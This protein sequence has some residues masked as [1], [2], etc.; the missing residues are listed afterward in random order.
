[1]GVNS[2][3][4]SELIPSR[5][6][7]RDNCLIVTDHIFSLDLVNDI[8]VIGAGKASAAMGAEIEKIL[9]SRI[10]AGHIIVKKGHSCRLK[11]IKVTEAGHP[12]PDNN[13][14]E[15]TQSIL[16]MVSEANANDLV[17]CLISGG[18]SS[19]LADHPEGSSPGEMILLNDLLVRSGASISEIN[20]VRKHLSGVKGG[21][22]ARAIYPATCIS[23]ILSDVPGD[24]LDVI[25]SGP[26][27]PDTT[28]FDDAFGVLSK[29]D[30]VR[31]MPQSLL[32]HII[33]GQDGSIPETPHSADTI[34]KKTYNILIGTNS[35]ALE[36]A[37]QKALQHN[38]NAIIVETELQGDV[39]TVAEYLVQAALQFRDNDS[40]VKPVCLLFGGETTIKVTGEGKGGRNQHLVLV[41]S[42]LLKDQPAITILSGGTD[43]NDGNS[44]AAG[45]VAD[46]MTYAAALE[47]RLD[48]EKYIAG[49]DSFNFFKKAGGLIATGPTMTN[50]MDLIVV[51][52]E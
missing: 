5:V 31:S 38:I 23:L 26:T 41:A 15:A 25:A 49:F 21:Q 4:P 39:A 8:Y 36:A 22:L 33:A 43:G 20:A 50:V 44:N 16:S 28:T 19:L 42:T 18:G 6:K 37:K 29:Y 45:A 51:V 40:E 14:F 17:I 9:G 52:I 34:F 10:K 1:A 11:Q 2:V 24:P 7:I 48:P 47:K 32:K 30:L 3:I 27:V 46:S 13:G 12:V 35:T